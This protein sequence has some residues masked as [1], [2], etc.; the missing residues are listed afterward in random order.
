MK[1]LLQRGG[2]KAAPY[3]YQFDAYLGRFYRCWRPG[4]YRNLLQKLS[5]RI[6][7]SRLKLDRS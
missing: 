5:E 3:S 7:V 4:G 1:L 2:V 6:V